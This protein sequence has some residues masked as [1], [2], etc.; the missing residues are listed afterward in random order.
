MAW[1]DQKKKENSAGNSGHY[2]VAIHMP[3]DHWNAAACAEREFPA[4][5]IDYRPV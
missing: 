5:V 2:I 4:P 1:G 3:G